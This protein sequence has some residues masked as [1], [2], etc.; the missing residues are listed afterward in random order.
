MSETCPNSPEVGGS[1]QAPERSPKATAIAYF[2]CFAGIS[3]AKTLGA[4]VDLGV[5][6]DWLQLELAR[7]PLAGFE[8]KCS[9]ICVQGLRASRVTLKLG[10]AGPTRR[11]ADLRAL[12]QASPFCPRVI[13]RSLAIFDRLAAAWLRVQRG[14][15][16]NQGFPTTDAVDLLVEIVGTALALERLGI[17]EVAA[18]RMPLGSGL[19][20]RRDG[21]LPLPLPA[22]VEILKGVPVYGSDLN[23]ELVTPTGAAIVAALAG[24]FGAPPEMRLTDAGY[25][26]GK[27]SHDG[28]PDVLRVLVGTRP[29]EAPQ[30]LLMV[31]TGI[32][33]MNPEIFGYLMEQLFADGALDVFWTPI[34]MKKNRPATLVQVLCPPS[35]R[36]AVVQRLLSETTSTGVRCHTVERHSLFRETVSVQTPFGRLPVKRILDPDGQERFT[37]EYEVCRE[38]AQRRAIPL[39]RVY[40]LVQRAATE[41]PAP[42]WMVDKKADDR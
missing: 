25:G 42:D 18:S 29:A 13:A 11:P 7:L 41:G 2:D 17:G 4:L 27:N 33:D 31:A 39:R 32:D 16:E 1:G 30:H 3:G 38:V 28:L 6:P 40:E 20:Q 8:L 10:A 22:T 34:Y 24:D 9:E 23:A 5:P 19:I 36:E 26:A 12:I 15:S 37:P 14:W 21:W 35:R